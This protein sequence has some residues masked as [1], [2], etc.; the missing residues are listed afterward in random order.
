AIGGLGHAEAEPQQD[1]G[2]DRPV[3]RVR[4]DVGAVQPF[5][6]I[7]GALGQLGLHYAGA[8]GCGGGR[9][10]RRWG[11]RDRR[12]RT[13]AA[14]PEAGGQ[15]ADQEDHLAPPAVRS[16]VVPSTVVSPPHPLLLVSS[17]LARAF[18]PRAA[19]QEVYLRLEV[20][21]VPCVQETIVGFASEGFLKS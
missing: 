15:R 13:V 20:R 6:N 14:A 16:I 7:I 1:P 18:A 17:V 11:G 8:A 5:V 9:R 21:P 12:R 19:V 3:R 10:R 2:P 4:A